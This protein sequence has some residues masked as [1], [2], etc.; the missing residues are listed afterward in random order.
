MQQNWLEVEEKEFLYYQAVTV[1]KMWQEG[2][3]T[4]DELNRKIIFL[5]G[6]SILSYYMPTNPNKETEPILDGEL[7][8]K[9]LPPKS[10]AQKDRNL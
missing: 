8:R 2:D 9:W 1:G 7:Q 10:E 6:K 3:I 5:K 4:L